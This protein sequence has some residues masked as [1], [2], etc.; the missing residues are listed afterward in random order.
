[1]FEFDDHNRT[2]QIGNGVPP[3]PYEIMIHDRV[4]RLNWKIR[5][6]V[7]RVGVVSRLMHGCRKRWRE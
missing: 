7:G 3:Y 4:S 2:T 6:A 5:E 1:M